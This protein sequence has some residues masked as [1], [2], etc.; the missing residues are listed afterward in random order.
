MATTKEVTKDERV[1]KEIRRLKR[2]YKDL[3]KD[4]LMVVEG[5]I[6]EAADLRIRLEDIREDLDVNGYDEM[7]SQS[8]QQE[9]YERERPQ[10]RRYIAMNKNYQS[11]MKQLGDYIPK[12]ELKKK[13]DGDD[14]F[15]AFVNRR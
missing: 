8:E 15:D 5:L 11:I 10:A 13:G 1:K 6:V 2:I 7:F 14:G 4:T 9:P 3:P 12:P